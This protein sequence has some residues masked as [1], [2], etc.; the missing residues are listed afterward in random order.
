M[1]S[2]VVRRRKDGVVECCFE[3]TP[4]KW[5]RLSAD[6]IRLIRHIFEDMSKEG[7]NGVFFRVP[8]MTE[9]VA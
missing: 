1:D 5:V 9:E 8:L 6:G 2:L 7:P 4:E 3:G